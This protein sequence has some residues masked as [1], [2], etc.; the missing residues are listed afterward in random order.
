MLI[1]K[2]CLCYLCCYFM[3]VMGHYL[4][5]FQFS[6]VMLTSETAYS[7]NGLCFL[8]SKSNIRAQR[9]FPE[10]A[11]ELCCDVVALASGFCQMK[12]ARVRKKV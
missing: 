11:F 5:K 6:F 10:L 12:L 7:T 2:F 8:V 9:P 3:K 4:N 1:F